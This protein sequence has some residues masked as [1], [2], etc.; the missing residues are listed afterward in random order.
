MEARS[1]VENI[2]NR[3]TMRGVISAMT[4]LLLVVVVIGAVAILVLMDFHPIALIVAMVL[5][6]LAVVLVRDVI[7]VSRQL[8][9]DPLDLAF[10]PAPSRGLVTPG[11]VF[12]IAGGLLMFG[13]VMAVV[14]WVRAPT[15]SFVAPIALIAVGMALAVMG[16]PTLGVQ[17][18]KWKVLAD[19]L[20]DHPE[21][22]PYLQD[23]RARFPRSAPFPFSAP[24]D[25]VTIP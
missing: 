7:I 10:D 6:G 1:Y 11:T 22:V 12:G 3:T 24:T 15:S 20:R 17:E 18:R 9:A 25:Q 4:R 8:R 16:V 19:A 21:L 2:A 13:I 23:A 5:T 14:L